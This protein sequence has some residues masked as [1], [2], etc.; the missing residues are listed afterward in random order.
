VSQEIPQIGEPP[1]SILILHGGALGDLVLTAFVADALRRAVPES[2]ITIAARNRVAYWLVGRGVFDRAVDLESLCL[3]RFYVDQCTEPLPAIFETH[4]SVVN[5]LGGPAEVLSQNLARRCDGRVVS[6]EPAPNRQTCDQPRHITE[7]WLADLRS[8]GVTIGPIDP[9]RTFIQRDKPSDESNSE[10]SVICH[11]GS[12]GKAK[13][14]PLSLFEGLMKRLHDDAV[15]A[16]WMVGP[17]ERD[18]FGQAFVDRLKQSGPVIEEHD[19]ASAA[20]ALTRAAVF[21]GN[22]AGM[23]HLAGAVGLETIALFGPTDPNIWRPLGPRVRTI[24]S[25]DAD[26]LWAVVRDVLSKCAR[27]FQ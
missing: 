4:D 13:C 26:Q 5:F 6:I 11:P 12:G 8:A 9:N 23:T 10:P 19:V 25:H 16:R 18:W 27:R 1:A 14:A 22:D 3:H 2:R 24:R 7:Q 17:V 20:D 15:S 21:V